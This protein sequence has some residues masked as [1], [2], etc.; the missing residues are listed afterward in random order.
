MAVRFGLFLAFFVCIFSVSREAE[1]CAVCGAADPTLPVAGA[2]SAFKGR[3]RMTSDA[4]AAS[5]RSLVDQTVID[6]RRLEL[7]PSWAPVSDFLISAGVPIVWRTIGPQSDVVLGDVELRATAVLWERMRK[8]IAV[9]GGFRGPSAPLQKDANG[10]LLPTDLQPGCGSIV[11]IAGAYFSIARGLW[12]ATATASVFLPTPVRDGPHPGTSFRI[13]AIGQFQPSKWFGVRLG[14]HARYDTSGAIGGQ[15]DPQSGGAI[16]YVV[17]EI[18]V[19]PV[20][21]LVFSAGASFPALQD[22]RGYRVASPV[23]LV[24]ASYDF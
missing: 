22:L 21:D 4:R 23:A 24:S 1:G 15:N 18:I 13:G 11:T 6:E 16:V 17:P 19:S 7:W 3:L 14:A 9:F 2:E 10:K 5:F 8:R 20:T 12:S